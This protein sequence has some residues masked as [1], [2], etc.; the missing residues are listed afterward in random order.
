MGYAIMGRAN[1]VIK[2]RALIYQVKPVQVS[3]YGRIIK[4]IRRG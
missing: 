2:Y 3:K 4:Y 1:T